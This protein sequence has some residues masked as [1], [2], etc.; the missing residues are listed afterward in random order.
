MNPL[1]QGHSG[2][3]PEPSRNALSTS[4]GTNED[5]SQSDP[6]PESG[7]FHGQMTQ[8]SGPGDGHDTE[9]SNYLLDRFYRW[10]CWAHVIFIENLVP[11]SLYSTG[12]LEFAMLIT[13]SLKDIL[14]LNIALLHF[15]H[16]HIWLLYGAL[17]FQVP[18]FAL[19]SF[20]SVDGHDV[21]Y[22]FRPTSGDDSAR[23]Y[24]GTRSVLFCDLANRTELTV[25]LRLLKTVLT[26][27][28]NS[29][30]IWEIPFLSCHQ[31]ELKVPKKH[32]STS[33]R[34]IR[35]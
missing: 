10:K 18:W 28:S 25:Y 3:T 32:L 30:L 23:R 29:V 15:L 13:K 9:K 26:C 5:D 34:L 27:N 33:W 20:I 14:I 4:Q 7:L 16:Q 8:N 1:L 17:M 6:H 19:V 35:F 2:T 21:Q 24:S 11:Y 22:L 12:K 31:L